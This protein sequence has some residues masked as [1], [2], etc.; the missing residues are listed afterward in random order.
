MIDIIDINM[1][2]PGYSGVSIPD[3]LMEAVQKVI[4]SKEMGFTSKADFVKTAIRE[5]LKAM[6]HD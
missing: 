2:R 4:D 6:H 1:T 5:K 3:D